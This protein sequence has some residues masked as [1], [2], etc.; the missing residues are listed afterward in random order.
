MDAPILNTFWSPILTVTTV[1]NTGE[2]GDIY[3]PFCIFQKFLCL[4][5]C[6]AL[7]NLG[8]LWIFRRRQNSDLL[9]HIRDCL[10]RK[11]KLEFWGRPRHRC[12][13]RR[14]CSLWSSDHVQASPMFLK[15]RTGF[16]LRWDLP[17]LKVCYLRFWL[18]LVQWKTLLDEKKVL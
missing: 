6:S 14:W 17:S 8:L 10:G 18:E 3:L 2:T 12:R 4:P 16:K 5:E 11:R 9:S 15:T 13:S 1:W 7:T